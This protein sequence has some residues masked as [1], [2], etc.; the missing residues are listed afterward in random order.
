MLVLLSPSKNQNFKQKINSC[1]YSEPKF[2]QEALVLVNILR[3]YSVLDFMEKFNV[4]EKIAKQ[5]HIYYSNW[6]NSDNEISAAIAAYSGEAFA[7]LDAKTLSYDNL[8]YAQKHLLILCSLYGILR[9]MDMIEAYRLDFKSI[10]TDTNLYDYW[11]TRISKLIFERN[12]E[13]I[14][15]LSSKE[16]SDSI[17]FSII[18]SKCINVEFKEFYGDKLRSIVIYIKKARGAM[19]RFIIEN[20]IEKLDDLK[21]FNSLGYEYHSLKENTLLF[22]RNK[23]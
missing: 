8:K 21:S 18:K 17:D 11:K 19:A 22:T 14:I 15:N 7:G 5:S 20:R 10:L 16:Y 2:K 9:P 13:F 4:S 3:R 23:L 1:D 6:G 12:D